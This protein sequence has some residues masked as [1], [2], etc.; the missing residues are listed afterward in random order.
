MSELDVLILGGGI[1]GLSIAQCL[2]RSGLNVEVWEGSERVGGK[3]QT[4]EKEGFQLE[5][6]ASM[7]M[8]FRSEINQ[9]LH[10]AQLDT[11]KISRAPGSRRYVLNADQLYP[12][13]SNISGLLTTPLFSTAAKLRLLAEPL[14]PRGRNPGESVADFVARRLGPEILE[15]VFEPYLAGPLASNIDLA[16]ANA[17]MP[18]LTALEKSYG[19][20]TL[21][22]LFRKLAS[23][24]SAARP[25]AFTF[26]G[27]MTSLTQTLASQ[28]DFS[29]RTNQRGS[30]VW[31]VKGG[32]M[33]RGV[34][35]GTTR[36]TFSRYLV[37]STPSDA[38][39]DLI[40]GLDFELAR[41]LRAIEYAPLKIVH[42][43]FDRSDIGHSLDGS[44]F[45]LPRRSS[46]AANGCLW[47]S[48]LFPC[49]APEGQVLFSNYLGGAR[50]PDA[51]GWG[52]QRTLDNVMPM[53]KTLLGVKKDP[54]ML[55]IKT[56]ERALPLYHGAYSQRLQAI[57]QRLDGLPGLYLEANYRGGVSVRDRILR[58]ELVARRILRQRHSLPQLTVSVQRPPLAVPSI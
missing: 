11:K 42:T 12:V 40:T 47:M 14:M 57:D 33:T 36:T 43:G 31:P 22:T 10:S 58:A 50:N 53:L 23:R 2:A 3:I 38:A 46:F 16:E 9:F 29:L 19:S 6:A 28:G 18:R 49:H 48:S 39:A 7:V 52:E 41:L 8:N 15:K 25:Q 13:P 37:L 55:H 4:T 35:A 27:G 44:G 5:D 45:L 32:W 51:V 30:E 20:L 56:H 1:S 17:T 54:G 34:V 26:S 24:G 21:G